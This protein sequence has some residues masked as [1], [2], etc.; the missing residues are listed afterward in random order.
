MAAR[1]LATTTRMNKSMR[2]ICIFTAT[3]AEWGLLAELAKRIDHSPNLEL[4]ILASG[5]HL[6]D[7]HG[8]TISEI[9][10]VGINVAEAIDI[11]EPGD[12]SLALCKSM[13]KAFLNYPEAL[14]RIAPDLIIILGDR[15]EAFCAATVAHI[16]QIPI[17]HIHGGESTEGAID[18]TFRHSITKLS[19][20]HFPAHDVY[21]KRI[22]QL[23]E[24]PSS[25]HM[26]GSLGVENIKNL[27]LLPKDALEESLKFKL[28]APFFLVTFHPATLSKEPATKQI[29]TV[30]AALGGHL[31][32]FKIILTKANA[33]PEGEMINDKLFAFANAHPDR[34]RLYDSMGLVRYLSA[35]K[36]C[37]AVIGNSSSGIIEAPALGIPSVNIGCRQKGRETPE[38]VINCTLTQ[39]A[40][41]NAIKTACQPETKATA[42]LYAKRVHAVETSKQ[43]IQIIHSADLSSGTHKSF[44]DFQPS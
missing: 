20:I 25:V 14:T 36:L 2:R 22:I 24:H 12:N 8:R 41:L 35:M 10:A 40:I 34:C 23:G 7:E 27:A 43:I 11:I 28:D 15:Y 26:V 1:P 17:A 18:E 33:D 39:E 31:Q 42:A 30:L 3:R 37:T 16:L 6:S 38:T 21:R 44:H 29:E 4:Q 13:S 19:Q 5:T 9:E 32:D